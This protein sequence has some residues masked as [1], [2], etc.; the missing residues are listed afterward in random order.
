VAKKV[1]E[2][3]FELAG[4]VSS[5]FSSSFMAATK[6]ANQLDQQIK[7]LNTAQDKVTRFREFK[8]EI[9]DTEKRFQTAQAEVNRLAKELRQAEKPTREMERA[10]E[11]AKRE[12]G[13][14]KNK[15]TSQRSELQTLR[16]SL[17]EAGVS[18]RNLTSDNAKLA[19]ELDRVTAAKDKQNRLRGAIE[20]N[21]AAKGR[22]RGQLL[23]TV[24]LAAAVAA[25]VK[26]A[27]DFESSMADVKK[28]VDF[29]TPQQFKAMEKDILSMTRT[30]PMTADQLAQI[31]AAGGQ[32]GIEKENLTAFAESAAKMGVAFDI[33]ADEAG[34]MMAGWRTAFRMNQTDVI[35]LAD[36]INYL[37]NTT[38][39]SAPKIS[40]VVT[41]IGPLGEVAGLASGEIAALGATLVGM[42][43]SE[44][45]A[46]TGIKNLML[47]LTAGTAATK[48]QQKAFARLGFNAET[49]AEKM[50]TD[51]QGAIFDVLQA[52]KKLPE[53]TQAS[54]LTELFGK[55][56][57]GAIAPLL[58][59]LEELE[60]N[61]GKV[62]DASQYAASME[63][64]FKAR[65]ETTENAL[66][67]A[68][69]A[70]KE[71]GISVGSILLPPLAQGAQ[72]LAKVGAKAAEFAE[73]H[74]GLAKAIV[75]STTAV[76]GLKIAS[77]ALGYGWTLLKG[78]AL[79][80]ASTITKVT[81][82][83][84]L[85]S[86]A[87]GIGQ[88]KA[89]AVTIATKAWAAAQWL[90]NAA[91]TANPIGLVIVGIA[92]LV[93]GLVLL[94]KKSDKAR[95][96]MDKLW[97]GIKTG[98]ADAVNWAIDEINKLIE[99]LNKIPGVYISTINEVSVKP[100]PNR[101]SVAGFRALDAQYQKPGQN[102]T[103][104]RN[105]GGG[106]SQV[107]E[108]G[109][110]I[111]DLPRGSRVYPH[112]VSMAMA[113]GVGPENLTIHVHIDGGSLDVRK[114]AQQGVRMGLS[115]FTSLMREWKRQEARVAY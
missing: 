34:Q 78:S 16:S 67:L 68:S 58:T 91:L 53:A 31:V 105:W 56:S 94:Y 76:I 23:D 103:G 81:S 22:Y 93:A 104:T 27:I 24:A 28:V 55:E 83:Q 92:A 33:S 74:P 54:I 14:F 110:E 17:S 77:V 3:A 19:R 40:A 100:I 20:T 95:E 88:A 10:F 96:V 98:V 39:A 12:A 71:M 89:I 90:L 57:V 115:E 38:A 21:E 66:I 111:I 82:G 109:G 8:K 5:S 64:E 37:G 7:K 15:L 87:A 102:A 101:T 62:G 1:Y 6:N 4:K 18:T 99:K 49:L 51:A 73:K 112:D 26:A 80:L 72:V 86:A 79:S 30:I 45:I 11:R 63:A 13:S 75:Y 48:K 43:I 69:N 70:A 108:R 36:K 60:K 50:Q 84:A 106:L 9:G 42:N 107:N 85:Q 44:E 97:R 25:P 52:I 114:Q 61:M 32:A 47:G 41:R 2:I 113:R 46:S 35:E 59:N 29:D 65:S